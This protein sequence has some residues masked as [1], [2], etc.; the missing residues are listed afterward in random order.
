MGAPAM[1]GASASATGLELSLSNSMQDY[2]TM[3]NTSGSTYG[4][5]YAGGKTSVFLYVLLGVG[6]LV[7]L[8]YFAN[9]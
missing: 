2:S 4:D 7:A 5:Y 1:A 8:L 6:G 9:K 3:V